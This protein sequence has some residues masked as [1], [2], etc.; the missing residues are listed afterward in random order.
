MAGLGLENCLSDLGCK[1]VLYAHE[2]GR[3]LSG[4]TSRPLRALQGN[5]VSPGTAGGQNRKSNSQVHGAL[6]APLSDA[7]YTD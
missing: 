7:I 4:G 5:T 1:L 3:G 2:E 6:Y